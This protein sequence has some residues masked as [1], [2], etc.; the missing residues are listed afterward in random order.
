MPEQIVIFIV[1]TVVL[2]VVIAIGVKLFVRWGEGSL[3]SDPRI[4]Q[5]AA[6]HEGIGAMPDDEARAKAD[7][8]LSGTSVFSKTPIPADTLAR[9][10]PQVP[11]ALLDVWTRYGAI[12]DGPAVISPARLR[13]APQRLRQVFRQRVDEADSVT[14]VGPVDEG[15]ELLVSSQGETVFEVDDEG[16]EAPEVTPYPSFYHWI[17]SRNPEIA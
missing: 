4:R 5:W 10:R 14:S 2:A 15:V 9:V 13:P 3:D 12:Q 7:T 6:F 16:P 17:L 8:L 11:Q 1:A